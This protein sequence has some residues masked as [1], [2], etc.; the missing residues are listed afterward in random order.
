MTE[1]PTERKTSMSLPV[2]G[3]VS[4]RTAMKGVGATLGAAAFVAAI[5]PLRHL[6]EE[7]TAAEFMQ[8]HYKEL[9]PEEKITRLNRY[10]SEHGSLEA[11][12]GPYEF[13]IRHWESISLRPRT[14]S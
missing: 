3:D 7:L 8:K 1:T 9:S 4:R 14:R 11:P 13:D 5:S 10:I 2:L 12:A 6:G